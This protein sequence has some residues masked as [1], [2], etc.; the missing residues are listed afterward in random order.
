MLCTSCT[1]SISYLEATNMATRDGTTRLLSR[2]CGAENK[3]LF[4]LSAA[5]LELDTLNER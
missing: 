5:Q 4:S 2:S 1:P 3:L